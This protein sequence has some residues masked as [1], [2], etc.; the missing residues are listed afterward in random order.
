[1]NTAIQS[2]EL[3]A[4][5]ALLLPQATRTTEAVETAPPRAYSV[6]AAYDQRREC[7]VIFGGF[8]PGGGYA[9]QTWEWDKAGWRRVEA[10]G[11]SP[12]NSPTLAF[13][14]RRGT[15]LLFGGDDRR[16]PKGDTWE[17]N[18]SVWTQVLTSGPGPNP[19][20]NARLAY[21]GKRGTTILY[22][23]F[24]GQTVFADAWEL[25][26]ERW[27]LVSSDGPPRF[28]H[29]FVADTAHRSWIT[30]GGA[31]TPPSSAPPPALGETWIFENDRWRQWSGTG[32][33]VRDHVTL[34]FD[35]IRGRTL[36]YGASSRATPRRRPGSGT[37]RRGCACP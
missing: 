13:D 20:T 1:M 32:P 9:G 25:D 2:H 4:A 34:A 31:A 36:L 27:K 3:V 12:R 22:G 29:G 14:E 16:G 33:G 35:P 8:R 28:L 21:D 19:R 6:G 7:L 18:G 23:G 11:P 5:L 30:Y 17:W 24:A 37:E 26:G 15:V 10:D